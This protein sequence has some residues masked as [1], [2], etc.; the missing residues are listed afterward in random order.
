MPLPL[1]EELSGALCSS[2]EVRN[3]QLCIR[4]PGNEPMCVSMP[5]LNPTDFQFAKQ[6]IA[7]INAAL[8]PYGYIFTII[9]VLQAVFKC[10]KAIPDALGPPPDPTAILDCLTGLRETLNKLIRQLPPY[11]IPQMVIDV[12][13]AVLRALQGIQ[14]EIAAII[15]ANVKVLRAALIAQSGGNLHLAAAVDCEQVS[16]DAQLTNLNDSIAPINRFL[17][18]LKLLTD[19]TGGVFQIPVVGDIM[20]E[21][22]G[23]ID[24]AR[25]GLDE[26][27]DA[28]IRELANN[29]PG[30]SDA[31]TKLRALKQ[32]VQDFQASIG[33]PPTV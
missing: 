17:G 11:T 29:L 27:T 26:I 25:E 10:I 5:D 2:I 6:L 1:P 13:D 12:A 20:S 8:A 21:V 23:V 14:A 24:G 32:Q 28:E 31:I 4:V 7:Q 22:Q 30:L 9:D 18:G 15:I 33:P 19:L 16:L 3:G